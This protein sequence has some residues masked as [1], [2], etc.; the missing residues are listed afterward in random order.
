MSFGAEPW[1]GYSNHEV[2][3]KVMKGEQMKCPDS[4]PP[5]IHEVMQ[6]VSD[7]T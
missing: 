4:I 1:L 6:T 5:K 3:E 2:K 7:K